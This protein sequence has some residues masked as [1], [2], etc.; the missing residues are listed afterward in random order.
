MWIPCNEHRLWK[1]GNNFPLKSG[2][3]LWGIPEMHKGSDAETRSPFWRRNSCACHLRHRGVI[4]IMLVSHSWWGMH[5]VWAFWPLSCWTEEQA[6]RANMWPPWSQGVPRWSTFYRGLE[7]FNNSLLIKTLLFNQLTFLEEMRTNVCSY[8]IG[9]WAA[10]QRNDAN[11]VCHGKIMNL[12]RLPTGTWLTQ[13]QLKT[14]LC[15][16]DGSSKRHS[17]ALAWLCSHTLP[18]QVHRKI[19]SHSEGIYCLYQL[20][21]GGLCWV[22]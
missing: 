5:P 4:K 7:S 15:V 12:L 3:R 22:L 20:G 17:A 11:R 8:Q 18:S 2:D 16:S 6:T 1:N 14:H 10:D 21:E 19:F 13:R 9:C